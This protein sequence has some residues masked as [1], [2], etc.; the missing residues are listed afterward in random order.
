MELVGKY[1]LAAAVIGFIPGSVLILLPLEVAMVYHLSTWNRRPFQL[2][3]LSLIW[4]VLLFVSGVLY[5]I[6]GS[7]FLWFGP[8][9]WLA[10]GLFAGLFVL[11]FG[12]LVD[13]YYKSENRKQSR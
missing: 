2:G 3:E 12:A 7:I 5:T 1:A 10:K 11:S 13:W 4:S 8:A 9:G 6:V